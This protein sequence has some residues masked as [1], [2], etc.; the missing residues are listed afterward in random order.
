MRND[1]TCT[2][3]TV[4]TNS[5]SRQDSDTATN[6]DIM[7]N[8]D[9][10]GPLLARVAFARKRAM[11]RRIDADIRTYE[12]V[13]AKSDQCLVQDSQAEISKEN[14]NRRPYSKKNFSYLIKI[15]K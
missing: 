11:A 10:F 6:P 8:I 7:T 5:N 15:I 2:N 4:V 9:R 3:R 12:T 13:V 14:F 1:R